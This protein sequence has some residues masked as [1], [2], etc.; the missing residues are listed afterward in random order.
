MACI[1]YRKNKKS[2]ITYAFRQ[3]SYRDP[4]TKKPRNTRT[5]LGRVDPETN[6]IIEKVPRASNESGDEKSRVKQTVKSKEQILLE[7]KDVQIQSLLEEIKAKDK[8]IQS[9]I[10]SLE[11]LKSLADSAIK[12]S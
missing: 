4:V 8:R 5:Y 2:G 12:E 6:T 3:E 7:R 10:K 9:L 11:K 1:V